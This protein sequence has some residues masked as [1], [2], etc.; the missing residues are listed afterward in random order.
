MS[1]DSANHNFSGAAHEFSAEPT[2]SHTTESGTEAHSRHDDWLQWLRLTAQAQTIRITSDHPKPG[3]GRPKSRRELK[4]NGLVPPSD[5]RA[6][7][8]HPEPS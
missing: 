4:L 3:P 2:H 1:L 5:Q 7:V 6:A 8:D